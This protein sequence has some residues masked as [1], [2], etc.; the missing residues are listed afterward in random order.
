MG[1]FFKIYQTGFDSFSF[2]IESLNDT[3]TPILLEKCSQNS[4]DL[5]AEFLYKIGYEEIIDD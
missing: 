4:T 1:K 2:E 5:I 3:K